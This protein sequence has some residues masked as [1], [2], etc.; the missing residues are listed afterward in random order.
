MSNAPRRGLGRV[1][2]DTSAYYA[3]ADPR[4]ANHAAA[5]AIIQ[6]V[7]TVPTRLF[8]TNIILAETHA[9]LLA[10]RGRVVAWRALQEIDRSATTRMRISP[11]DEQLARAVIAQYD[12]NDFALTD[13]SSF[14]VMERLRIAEA[15]SFDRHFAQYGFPALPPPRA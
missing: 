2:I 5:V 4:D 1:L 9:L 12:D 13:A 3:L 10:R 14:A 8:T 11:A 7:S 15:F 6:H